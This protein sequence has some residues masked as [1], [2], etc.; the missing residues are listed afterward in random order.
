MVLCGCVL[1]DL[2]CSS[3]TP[4]LEPGGKSPN[5]I[6]AL[7]GSTSTDAC[8]LAPAT[9]ATQ[10]LYVG[11]ISAEIGTSLLLRA[12]LTDTSGNALSGKTI[13]F[14][15]GGQTA[16]AQSDVNGLAR[17]EVPAAFATG[18]VAL[19]ISY[20]GEAGIAAASAQATISIEREETV[21]RYAGRAWLRAEGKP[22]CVAHDGARGKHERDDDSKCEEEEHSEKHSSEDDS[23][24][25]PPACA[26][27]SPEQL[28][29]LLTKP[30]GTPLA[31]KLI[32]FQVAGVS[33][34]ATT[35]ASGIAAAPSVL[36]QD[37]IG[38]PQTIQMAFA[39]D[40]ALEPAAAHT[41]VS[42][43]LPTALVIRRHTPVAMGGAI[44]LR[45]EKREREEHR[46]DKHDREKDRGEKDDREKDR[47]E[48]HHH[49]EDRGE[50]PGQ[51]PVCSCPQPFAGGTCRRVCF[52][53]QERESEHD[54][55]KLPQYFGVVLV[56]PVAGDE[57]EACGE[58]AGVAVLQLPPPEHG[59]NDDG[60]KHSHDDEAKAI[61]VGV[62]DSGTL[63]SKAASPMATQAQPA[64]VLPGEAYAVAL[65]LANPSST[66]ATGVIADE[67]FDDALPAT[68]S[69]ALGAV[70]PSASAT[71]AETA[72]PLAPR[73]RDEP[74][75][76]YQAR[77]GA[78]E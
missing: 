68:S 1:A 50:E 20:A 42:L 48:K 69:K 46:R 27:P 17:A 11:D 5:R 28:R 74:L 8:G 56:D 63:L 7:A 14:A 76:T 75:A 72:P 19:H 6:A 62:I 55:K 18:N 21:L 49:E 39:G 66:I 64:S 25:H 12:L 4:S 31:G 33:A 47:G 78:T 37:K 52:K 65:Q 29:A 22:P 44:D 3:R 10:L 57:N 36:P 24:E 13:S 34:T 67:S 45:G 16:S 26:K 73:G 2:G 32:S 30:D 35:D 53:D 40:A 9:I 51:P 77:L 41:G 61:L 15:I 59:H 70:P 43:F 71:F 60:E 38:A 23:G 54:R 58:I